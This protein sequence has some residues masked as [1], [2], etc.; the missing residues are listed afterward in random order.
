MF[1]I[2]VLNLKFLYIYGNMLVWQM[3]GGSDKNWVLEGPT[4]WQKNFNF[5]F[6]D[7]CIIMVTKETFEVFLFNMIT[8][9]NHGQGMSE[10]IN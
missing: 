5:A 2:L 9:W 10:V 7:V 1:L 6:S 3:A 8:V 4:V